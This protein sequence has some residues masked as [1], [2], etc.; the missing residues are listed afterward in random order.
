MHQ[1]RYTVTWRVRS[2]WGYA[3]PVARDLAKPAGAD[4]DSLAADIRREVQ[5]AEAAWQDAVAHAIRAGELLIE[6]KAQV[7]HG[8]WLPW[9]DANFP[10]SARSAQGYMRL[11]QHAEEAQALAHLGVEGALKQLAAPKEPRRPRGARA[12]RASEYE[13]A[14]RTA[15]S[16]RSREPIRA[17]PG[18]LAASERAA[19]AS[20][21]IRAK[22]GLPPL[23]E[24]PHVAN[25]RRQLAQA[26][27]VAP[28]DVRKV[29]ASIEKLRASLPADSPLHAALTEA[30]R[31][32]Q[33][34]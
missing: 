4:L 26:D 2:W 28:P 32:L 27:S 10:G 30:L 23:P 18:A 3:A 22:A 13:I 21:R 31:T 11:A 34:A 1:Q 19:L 8:H 25:L 9:L 33:R 16:Q 6:A 20:A 17:T 5:A 14:I 29:I 15:R 24:T 7:E 12:P